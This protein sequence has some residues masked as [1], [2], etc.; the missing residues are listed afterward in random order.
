MTLWAISTRGMLPRMSCAARRPD[1]TTNSN[2]F[3]PLGR[4]TTGTFFLRRLI[5]EHLTP[6]YTSGRRLERAYSVN[7]YFSSTQSATMP[8]RQV[9]FLPSS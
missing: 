8:S 3:V 5:A 4:W 7:R 9:I 2:A 6:Q 1:T